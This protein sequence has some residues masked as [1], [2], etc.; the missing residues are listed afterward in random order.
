MRAVYS[1]WPGLT[2][3]WLVQAH[4]Y[5]NQQMF[6]ALYGCQLRKLTAI[7]VLASS[8]LIL[9]LSTLIN[10]VRKRSFLKLQLTGLMLSIS[11]QEQDFVE[12]KYEMVI[13]TLN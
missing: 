6:L 5:Q 10:R 4:S 9:C 2:I 12:S 13:F 7:K 3:N 11:T 1:Y 8:S